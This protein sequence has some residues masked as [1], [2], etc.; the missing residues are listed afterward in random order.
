MGQRKWTVKRKIEQWEY[1]D[2]AADTAAQALYKVD[3]F[4]RDGVTHLD[5]QHHWSHPSEI[6]GDPPRAK[7]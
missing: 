1:F 7:E 4:S 6:L 2:V 3:T 5:T